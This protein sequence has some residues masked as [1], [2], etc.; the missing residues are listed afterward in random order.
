MKMQRDPILS[1]QTARESVFRRTLCLLWLILKGKSTTSAT[2]FL[3]EKLSHIEK[4]LRRCNEINKFLLI[5]FY[6]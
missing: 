3:E 1:W 4:H 6:L 5:L 2:T